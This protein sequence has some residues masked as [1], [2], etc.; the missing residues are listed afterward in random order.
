[1]A[2][3]R[4]AEILN[5]D[6]V[7]DIGA[8]GMLAAINKSEIDI[9]IATAR[10]WPRS[11][12]QFKNDALALA[13]LDEETAGS[14]FYSLKRG[15]GEDA[16]VIEGPSVRLAEVCGSSWGHFRY[17][18]RSEVTDSRF[19]TGQGMAFDLQKNVAAAIEVKRRITG[20]D[21]R[22]YS[23]DMIVV[24]QNAAMSIAL[25]NAIFKVIP[26]ALVKP[27]YEAAKLASLG[28]GMTMEQRRQRAL[29]W[30]VTKQHAKVADVL[31]FLE[32]KGLEDISIE[33]L[34]T[35]QGLRTAI[36]D[37]DTTWER[38]LREAADAEERRATVVTPGALSTDALL[39][40]QV[41]GQDDAHGKPTEEVLANG[42]A[43][44][45]ASAP[46]KPAAA[47]QAALGDF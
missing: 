43:K 27:I 8:G 20:R 6:E 10:R 38:S 31:H 28:K 36:M 3:T 5:E 30:F 9:Q 47:V 35:L 15:R 37:G 33:D 12:E 32:R 24:T 7:R 1:M 11:I 18:S 17:G 14:M 44:A 34:Q 40:G 25:R 42:A 29:D 16:K 45:E 41:A 23:E 26:F 46:S 4:Q 2:E 21:G 13:T 22:T 39:R 19:V